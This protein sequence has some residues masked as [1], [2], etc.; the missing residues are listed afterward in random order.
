MKK[1]YL[2]YFSLSSLEANVLLQGSDCSYASHGSQMV[3]NSTYSIKN[4]FSVYQTKKSMPLGSIGGLILA[5][6]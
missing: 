5:A 1:Y 2:L 4:V 6:E 3:E